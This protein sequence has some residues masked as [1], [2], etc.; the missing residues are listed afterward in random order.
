MSRF[1]DDDYDENFPNQAALYEANTER[2]LAGKRGQ[3]FLREM[4]SALIALPRKELIE[5]RVCHLGQVC[6]MGALALKRRMDTGEKFEAAIKWLED[7][8]P[9]E[10][11]ASETAFF[12]EKHF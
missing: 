5:G 12:A 9:G 10:G 11:D 7:E 3:A 1:Y 4:E 6:A 8:A 2:A